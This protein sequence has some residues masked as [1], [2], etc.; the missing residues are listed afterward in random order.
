MFL[1]RFLK[2]PVPK[3]WGSITAGVLISVIGL[4]VIYPVMNLA[5]EVVTPFGIGTESLFRNVVQVNFVIE[6]GFPYL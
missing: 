1:I 5:L 3:Q 6:L 2:L 4:T